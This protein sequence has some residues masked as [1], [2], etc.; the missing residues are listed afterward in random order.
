[1]T[2]RVVLENADCHWSPVTSGVPHAN[3]LGPLLY[4]LF[5]NDLPDEATYGVKVALYA[6]DTKL[7]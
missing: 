1:M 7:Y 4:T 6:D 3:I 2:Q 5:I